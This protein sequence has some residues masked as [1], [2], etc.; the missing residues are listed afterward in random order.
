M[1][2]IIKEEEYECKPMPFMPVKVEL[3]NAYVPFQQNANGFPQEEAL[4][5]GTMFPELYRPYPSNSDRRD[6]E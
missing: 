2:E 6:L 3:A 1:I 5:K 4:H